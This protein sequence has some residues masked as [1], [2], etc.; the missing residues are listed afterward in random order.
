MLNS[1]GTAEAV[2]LPLGVRLP[3]RPGRQG[4]T[5]GA[6]TA[7]GYYVFGGTYTS[8]ACLDWFRRHLRPR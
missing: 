5:Q 1:L 7:G 6:H 2:F 8:G 3:T 4:Y